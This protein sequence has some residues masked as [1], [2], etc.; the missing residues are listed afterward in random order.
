M[1]D[2]SALSTIYMDEDSLPLGQQNF[3]PL[4]E[5]TVTREMVSMVFKL[6]F[7]EAPRIVW[8]K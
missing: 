8:T 3:L 2:L 4:K 1:I 6:Y 7:Q 5:A